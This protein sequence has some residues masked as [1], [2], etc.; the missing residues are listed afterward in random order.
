MGVFMYAC[1]HRNHT[2][3]LGSVAIFGLV[4]V[5]CTALFFSTGR[6]FQ[7][8]ASYSI[9]NVYSNADW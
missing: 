2:R 8:S 5:M 9:D 6:L 4:I 1:L 3:V 7:K